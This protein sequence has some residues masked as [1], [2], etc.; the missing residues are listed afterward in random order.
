MLIIDFA[1]YQQVNGR[2]LRKQLH[3][4]TPHLKPSTCQ[5]Q[6]IARKAENDAHKKAVRA[7]TAEKKN[8]KRENA[9]PAKGYFY[10]LTNVPETIQP[11]PYV[12]LV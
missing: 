4:A 3:I 9:Q 5:A 8:L 10:T 7:G 2:I 11:L 12:D 1:I 6:I